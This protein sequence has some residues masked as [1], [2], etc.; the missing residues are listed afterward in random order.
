MKKPTRAGFASPYVILVIVIIVA[1]GYIGWVAWNRTQ[2]PAII[3]NQTAATATG[4]EGTCKLTDGKTIGM[5]YVEPNLHY[6]LC[7]PD[8]WQVVY[9]PTAGAHVLWA[10]SLVYRVGTNP[11]ATE[12]TDGKDGPL[13]LTVQYYTVVPQKITDG[14][15]TSGAVTTTVTNL[16]TIA[17]INVT[18]SKY[19]ST[20]SVTPNA[21]GI[22]PADGSVEYNYVFASTGGSVHMTYYRAPGDL[23]N[24]GLIDLVAKSVRLIR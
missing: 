8:G 6:S 16:G 12:S 21:E 7:I 19:E 5:E 18:G 1:V 17:A 20:F 24:S 13:P 14:T 2:T 9:N 10:S 4:L 23:D 15:T 22:G 3:Q 11:T